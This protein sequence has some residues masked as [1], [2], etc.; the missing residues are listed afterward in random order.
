MWCHISK[1]I[2]ISR[3]VT[4]DAN[5]ML[6]VEPS[7]SDHSMRTYSYY[8]TQGKSSSDSSHRC[9]NGVSDG[10]VVDEDSTVV[11]TEDQ[12]RGGASS[13]TSLLDRRKSLGGSR[14]LLD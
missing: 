4:F 2:I 12:T 1:K 11:S 10:T 14:I 3:H 13:E 5:A 8:R 7:S 9:T 6:K